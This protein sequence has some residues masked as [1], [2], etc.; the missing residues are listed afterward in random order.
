MRKIWWTLGGLAALALAGVVAFY[1]LV[2]AE[3]LKPRLIQTVQER[4]QRELSFDGP[5]GLSLFPRI[6]LTLPATTLS[7]R[8]SSEPFAHLDSARVS[9]A[10][11][12]LLRGK[13]EVGTITVDG[14]QA[15]LVRGRDGKTNIDDLLGAA[16]A[17][18]TPTPAPPSSGPAVAPADF[19]LGG[20][21]LNR[22]ELTL[23][24]LKDDKLVRLSQLNLSTGRIAPRTETELELSTHYSLKQ[25]ALQG[26]LKASAELKLDLPAASYGLSRL[27]ASSSGTL[28]GDSFELKLDAP[29]LELS[30]TAAKAKTATF[31]A[32]LAGASSLDL[33]LV[34]EGL[35][36]NN[37]AL[38]ANQIE[39]AATQKQ[40]ARSLVAQLAGPAQASLATRSLE[41]PQLKGQL[42]L[43]DPALPGGKLAA[44]LA[45]NLTIDGAKETARLK[46]DTRI[47]GGAV[48]LKADLNGFSQPAIRFDLDAA[49]LDLDH[50]LP[51]SAPPA[52]KPQAALELIGTAHAAAPTAGQIDLGFLKRLRL[53]GQVRVEALNARDIKASQVQVGLAARG[54]R[55]NAAPI[56]ARLYGGT[57]AGSAWVQSDNRL[58]TSLQLNGVQLAPLLRDAGFKDKLE[59]RATIRTELSAGGANQRALLQSLAG[60]LAARIDQGALRGINLER[61]LTQ[62]RGRQL[63]SQTERSNEAEKTEFS[64]LSA[65]FVIAQGIARNQD[66]KAVSAVL[67]VSGAGAIDLPAASIDYTLRAALASN[68]QRQATLT[69]PVK[70]S[71]P[72]ADI[73]YTID[74]AAVAADSIKQQLERRLAPG[75]SGENPLDALKQL[76]KR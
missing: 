1:L 73:H 44:P 71:G 63:G 3:A 76:F 26:Q 23:N 65:S 34:L 16:P 46:L 50:W 52:A 45:G 60:N 51:P 64:E 33:K 13:L 74:W 36:G 10:L 28:A 41:L 53:D 6:G 75:S 15:T 14:L 69:V 30:P 12:P 40:G 5:L 72:L 49:K 70:L 4:Y 31:S 39:L 56:N 9:V 27:T 61:I 43:T 22:A 42:D 17:T 29:Q 38:T 48:A 68:A 54:G 18:P 57:L 35:A 11:L 20:L 8:G 62:A 47:D 66:L 25:P 37:A 67:R 58:G 32:R 7:Q 21:K 59:G 24:D 2:D 19:E 55:L